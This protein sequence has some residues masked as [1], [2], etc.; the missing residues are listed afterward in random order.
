[1]SQKLLYSLLEGFIFHFISDPYSETVS[2]FLDSLKKDFLK[3]VSPILDVH[4]TVDES[5]GFS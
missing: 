2:K 5:L 3:A 1:M 4:I